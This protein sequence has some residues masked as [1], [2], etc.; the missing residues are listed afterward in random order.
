MRPD[1]HL[2]RETAGRLSG[3]LQTLIGVGRELG[4]LS[5]LHDDAMRRLPADHPVALE[6]EYTPELRR[7]R[8]RAPSAS[9][10]VPIWTDLR[11]RAEASV[12]ADA[13]VAIAVRDG[14]LRSRRARGRPEDL[15]ALVDAYRA[16]QRRRPG[17]ARVALAW[18]L[19]DRAWFA[20]FRGP[21]AR[22]ES[23]GD[24]AEASSL[25]LAVP[26][27]QSELAGLIGARAPTIQKGLRVWRR[28]G[29][30]TTGYRRIGINDVEAPA[31]WEA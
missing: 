6:M 29:I 21:D 9:A 4:G 15:D 27:S 23:P 26:L 22:R 12:G 3:R 5:A 18:A 16:E 19:R 2:E 28:Q 11:A 1:D 14:Q 10:S 30:V 17:G 8:D 13:A 25:R 31:R 24:L 7:D 20:R